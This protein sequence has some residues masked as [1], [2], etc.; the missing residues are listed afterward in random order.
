MAD[1]DFLDVGDGGFITRQP[2]NAPRRALKGVR[3]WVVMNLYT[4]VLDTKRRAIM[5]PRK[6]PVGA[7]STFARR[8][9][10]HRR[11]RALS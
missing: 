6:A 3:D 7:S 8:Y 4:F 5:Y 1:L 11:A 9:P 2:I 10:S